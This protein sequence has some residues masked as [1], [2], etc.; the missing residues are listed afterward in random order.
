MFCTHPILTHSILTPQTTA[1]NASCK[2]KL[3][4]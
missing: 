3:S 4:Y 1:P 2:Q